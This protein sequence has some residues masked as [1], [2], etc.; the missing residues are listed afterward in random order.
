MRDPDLTVRAQRAAT[1]LES[2]WRRW[3]NVHGLDADPMPPVSSYVGYSLDAPWGE[4]RVVLGICAEEAELPP[5]APPR[6]NRLDTTTP[7]HRRC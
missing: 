4:T 3:R 7:N 5:W 6:S 2:A 1:A